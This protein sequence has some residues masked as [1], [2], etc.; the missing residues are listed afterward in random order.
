MAATVTRP[1][2]VKAAFLDTIFSALAEAPEC[3]WIL[4]TDEQ[5]FQGLSPNNV[6]FYGLFNMSYMASPQ[7]GD[8]A[9]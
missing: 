9:S 8:L 5:Y 7:P 6:T 2:D 3:I 1:R 4:R